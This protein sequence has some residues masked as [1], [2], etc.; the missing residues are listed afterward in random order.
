LSGAETS[1]HTMWR[2][3]LLLLPLAG[4]EIWQGEGLVWRTDLCLV[5]AYCILAGGVI[6][7]AIWNQALRHWPT[8]QVLL[9]NNLIPLSTMTWAHLWLDE[10]FTSTFWLAMLLIISGVVI[11]QA[12]WAKFASPRLVPPE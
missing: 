7:F 12:N 4:L 2:A 1:A 11:G 9:F 5:Q 8:S 10:K 3:G 6:A